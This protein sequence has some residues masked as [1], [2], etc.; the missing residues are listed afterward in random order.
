MNIEFF[1][2]VAGVV[3]LL[4]SLVGAVLAVNADDDILFGL[5]SGAIIGFFFCF[6]VAFVASTITNA[7]WW[8]Q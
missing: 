1:V 7:G 8:I 2:T 6:V 3:A 4:G 5:V